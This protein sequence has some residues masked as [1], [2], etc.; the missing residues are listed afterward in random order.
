MNLHPHRDFFAALRHLHISAYGGAAIVLSCAAIGATMGILFPMR[1]K[2][3][4]ASNIDGPSPSKATSLEKASTTVAIAE[5][6]KAISD[7]E[8]GAS[9][10]TIATPLPKRQ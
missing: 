1:T 2:N 7:R 4:I 8:R 6:D 3:V 9:G 10:V 5:P